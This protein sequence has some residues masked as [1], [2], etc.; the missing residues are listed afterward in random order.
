MRK[1]KK[2]FEKKKNL[3]RL[4]NNRV[5]NGLL[6]NSFAIMLNWEVTIKSANLAKSFLKLIYLK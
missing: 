6:G 2:R 3:K 1:R 4:H 5:L